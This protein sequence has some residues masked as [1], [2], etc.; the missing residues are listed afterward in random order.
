MKHTKLNLKKLLLPFVFVSLLVCMLMLQVS[1]ESTD[2]MQITV[3]SM[4]TCIGNEIT[5]NVDV[6]GNPGVSAM[7]LSVSYSDSLTLTKIE[8]NNAMGGNSILPQNLT[9]PIKLTWADPTRDYTAVN[10]TF[11]T[12]TFTVKEDAKAPDAANI[13]IT[14][15]PE[16]IYN[17]AENNIHCA[18]NNGVITILPCVPGD[19]NGDQVVNMKDYSRLFQYIAGWDVEVNAPTL[20]VNGDGAVNMKDYSRLFQYIAG[21]DVEIY[22]K[23]TVCNHEY[24]NPTWTWNGFAASATFT[25]IHDASHTETLTATVTDQITKYPTCTAY[26][27]RTYT[28]TV[29][30]DGKTYTTTK[31][32]TLAKLS[33][34]ETVVLGYEPTCTEDGLTDGR[35]CVN[36]GT[37]IV[38]QTVIPATGHIET[39][40]PGYEA[41]CTADGLTNGTECAVCGTVIVSREIIPALG[42]RFDVGGYC[43]RCWE[44]QEPSEVLAYTWTDDGSAYVVSGIGTVTGT[45]I[46][47]PATYQ[48]IQVVGIADK[49][50]CE[51]SEITGIT[52]PESIISIGNSAFENCTNLITIY[53]E[54]TIDQWFGIR[55][56]TGNDPLTKALLYCDG[57]L[58]DPESDPFEMDPYTPIN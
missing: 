35:Q 4:T 49:A 38:S 17:L 39:T 25:C 40:L 23:F 7:Q 19:I 1:A 41:T 6:T 12:L 8:Y 37:V 3:D 29:A 53:Y 9:S 45:D 24:G 33:H 13:Q 14:Y 16:N 52:I 26:G 11:A 55:I 51:C 2:S 54:G 27:V 42:H 43:E 57:V 21:W 56:G 18:V 58:Y 48:G 20:D 30:L 22:P 46:V 5:V 50:F 32:E 36:C 31:N 10:F 15:D 44:H 34:D 47:I 28:A